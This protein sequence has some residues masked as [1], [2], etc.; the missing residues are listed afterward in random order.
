MMYATLII[1]DT[2]I[3]LDINEQPITAKNRENNPIN[4]NT[5]INIVDSNKLIIKP[6][7]N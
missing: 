5:M 2:V 7:L 6:L 3:R 1:N 4:V